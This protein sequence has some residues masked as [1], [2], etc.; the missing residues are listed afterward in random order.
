M[1]TAAIT[2]TEFVGSVS[3]LPSEVVKD[4][5]SSLGKPVVCDQFVRFGPDRTFTTESTWLII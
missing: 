2:D 4:N 5:N 1:A 3:L